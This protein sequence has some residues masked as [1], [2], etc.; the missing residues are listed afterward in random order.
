VAAKKE[1]N[2]RAKT[3]TRH[4]GYIRFR[5]SSKWKANIVSQLGALGVPPRAHAEFFRGAV[6]AAIGQAQ[7]AKSP[8]WQAFVAAVQ[9]HAQERL[10]MSLTDGGLIAIM[11]QG[12]SLTGFRNGTSNP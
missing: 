5:I 3:S 10:G 1:S 12:R 4:E 6:I 8:S 7:R 2:R 9:P 11:R